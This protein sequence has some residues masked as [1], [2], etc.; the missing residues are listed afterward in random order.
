MGVA[1]MAAGT[2]AA[3]YSNNYIP[4]VASPLVWGNLESSAIPESRRSKNWG[5]PAVIFHCPVTLHFHL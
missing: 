2:D 4:P 1:I 3:A 5:V